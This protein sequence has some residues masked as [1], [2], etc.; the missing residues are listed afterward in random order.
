MKEVVFQIHSIAVRPWKLVAYIGTFRF[1]ARWFVQF[2]RREN[3]QP[4]RGFRFLKLI[5]CPQLDVPAY[6][7]WGTMTPW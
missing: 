3:K 6:S 5:S 4:P 2:A 7:V 1:M